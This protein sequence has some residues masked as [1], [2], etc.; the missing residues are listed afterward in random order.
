M[1]KQNSSFKIKQ[2]LTVAFAAGAVLFFVLLFSFSDE[3]N[4]YASRLIRAQ[5]GFLIQKSEAAFV[6]SAFNYSKN[7]LE[8]QLTFLEFGSKTCSACQRM[9]AV[10]SDINDKFPER[11]NV[12]FIN[13]T[14]A[15]KL[16]FVKY[17]GISVIPTQVLLNKEG[18]EY[19]RHTGYFST[20]EL[21]RKFDFLD[22]D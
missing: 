21:I 17:M 6:D 1:Q 19:F 4:N 14:E 16:K 7:G 20:D 10:M 8:Y 12:V 11:V 2:V 5:A 15:E 9:E 3:I 13:V 18:K 22:E